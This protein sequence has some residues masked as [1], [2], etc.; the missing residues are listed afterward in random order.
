MMCPCCSSKTYDACCKSYLDGKQ[1]PPTAE[2]LMRSRYTA[3]SLANINYIA[4]TMKEQALEGFDSKD[5]KAWAEQVQWQKLDVLN[6]DEQEDRATV[7]FRAYYV[8]NGKLQ[9][10]Q[11]N[12]VFRRI[13]GR[14]YYI[15]T[16]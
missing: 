13:L 16:A 6:S 9:V 5:A 12:S 1:I 11:E 2:A 14:W 3:Y 4:D 15:G 8:Y 10:M 7:E